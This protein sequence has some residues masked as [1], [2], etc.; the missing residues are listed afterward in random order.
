MFVL[1]RFWRYHASLIRHGVL[2]ISH[3]DKRQSLGSSIHPVFLVLSVCA[4]AVIAVLFRVCIFIKKSSKYVLLLIF[5]CS[6]NIWRNQKYCGY[7][8]I[9]CSKAYASFTSIQ[10]VKARNCVVSKVSSFVWRSARL[11]GVF[12]ENIF[13]WCRNTKGSRAKGIKLA[14]LCS[15]RFWKSGWKNHTIEYLKGMCTHRS[16]KE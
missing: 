15:M 2:I 3:V 11:N 7:G 5:A 14:C 8:M 10:K 1:K 16:R 13:F 6:N 4:R 12:V 9:Y